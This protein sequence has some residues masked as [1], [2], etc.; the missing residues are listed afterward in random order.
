MLRPWN[1]G[2]RYPQPDSRRVRAI[3]ERSQH[4]QLR[5]DF[6]MEN[7]DDRW[8]EVIA[9]ME[10]H[11]WL[12]ERLLMDWKYGDKAAKG[13]PENKRRLAFV[14]WDNLAPSEGVKDRDQ[15]ARILELCG[16]ESARPD[17]EG[18]FMLTKKVVADAVKNDAVK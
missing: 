16:V 18:R 10:H 3:I 7:D 12:A 6:K 8:L 1:E 17:D 11:R 4:H 13:M 9:K 15:I 5:R 2:K 14:D